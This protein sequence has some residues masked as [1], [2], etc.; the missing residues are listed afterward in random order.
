MPDSTFAFAYMP[1]HTYVHECVNACVPREYLL[2]I[3]AR[4]R[5]RV[6]AVTVP[7]TTERHT[8]TPRSWISISIPSLY[9]PIEVS[10]IGAL[11]PSLSRSIC[12]PLTFRASL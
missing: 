3:H 8:A 11:H 4:M 12:A 1:V 5:V 9:D 10:L 2:E 6:R 7:D